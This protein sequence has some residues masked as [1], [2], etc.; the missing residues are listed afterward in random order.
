[1]NV[2]LANEPLV[3]I[4]RHLLGQCGEAIMVPHS[5]RV[6]ACLVDQSKEFVFGDPEHIGEP[7]VLRRDRVFLGNVFELNADNARRWGASLEDRL[8]ASSITIPFPLEPRYRPMLFTTVNVYG[9]IVLK[10]YD[11]SLT[12][13]RPIATN[14]KLKGGQVLHFEYRLGKH[15]RL[16]CQVAE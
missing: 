6:D 7:S 8:P 12:L 16:E 11:C 15:P 2:C 14:Q 3:M 4:A 1:M 13:P 10:D 5:V 9:D